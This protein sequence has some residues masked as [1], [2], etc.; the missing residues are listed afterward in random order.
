MSTPGW[1]NILIFKNYV[2]QLPTGLKFQLGKIC[3]VY[4]V[5]S[6]R[7]QGGF[8]LHYVTIISSTEKVVAAHGLQ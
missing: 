5:P 4:V 3:N 7:R 6:A 8:N 1:E 2:K